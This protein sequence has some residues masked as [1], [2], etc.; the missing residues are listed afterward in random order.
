M[1]DPQAPQY[2]FDVVVVGSGA[3]RCSPR[4]ARPTAACPS[5]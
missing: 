5:S 1:N 3:V 4:A 2:V